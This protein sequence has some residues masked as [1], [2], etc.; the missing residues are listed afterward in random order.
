[1]HMLCN[2]LDTS[3]IIVYTIRTIGG[4]SKKLDEILS[5]YEISCLS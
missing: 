2:I 5:S 4:E 3:V 1:M